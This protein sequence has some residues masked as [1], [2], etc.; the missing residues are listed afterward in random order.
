MNHVDFLKH[1][2]RREPTTIDFLYAA[3][4]ERDFNN[5]SWEE[6]TTRFLI[7][8][9][10]PFRD[11][12]RSTPHEFLY[13]EVRQALPGAYIDF[14]FFPTTRDRAVLEAGGVPLM[15]GIASAK[16]AADFDVLLVSNAYTLEM[17]NLAPYLAGSGLPVTRTGRDSALPGSSYP[18]VAL[19]GSNAMASAALYDEAT[20]DSLVDALFFGEGEGSVGPLAVHLAEASRLQGAE[21]LATLAAAAREVPGFWPTA[22]RMPVTQTKASPEAYPSGNPPVLAGE[23]SGTSRLEITRGC[24]SFCTFCFEG[25]ERKPFRERPF[26]SSI[27]EARRLKAGAGVDSIEL[28]SYNFNAHSRVVDIIKTLHEAFWSVSFQSQRVDMLARSPGLVTFEVAAGKR[29]FTIGVEGISARVRAYYTKE[30]CEADLRA[31]LERIVGEGAREIKLFYILSG[32][33]TDTDLAEF[34]GFISWMRNLVRER[35]SVPRIMFSAGELIRMPFTPL[36]YERLILDEAPYLAIRAR[37]EAVIA[38]AGFEYR[39]PERFDEYCL[40]QVLAL[41]PAGSLALLLALSARGHVYDRNLSRGAWDFTRAWLQE[42]GILAKDS[43][44]TQAPVH[45]NPY[46]DEKPRGYPFPY[47]F[48]TPIATRDIVYNR[49]LDA[50][51]A[52]ERVSCLGATCVGCGACNDDNEGRAERAFLAAHELDAASGHDLRDIES[53]VTAKRKPYETFV[54]ANLP[55]EAAAAPPAYPAVLF[56]RAL[57]AAVPDFVDTVWTASDSFLKSKD[58]LERL[59]GAWGDTQYRLLSSRPLDPDQLTSAGYVVSDTALAPGRLSVD[60]SFPTA[61]YAETVRLVSDFMT[62]AAM[63][64]TLRKTE[65]AATFLIAEKG[66]RKRNVLEATAAIGPEGGMTIKLVCGSKYDLGAFAALAEK[67]KIPYETRVSL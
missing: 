57:F 7:V 39:S 17:V 22:I 19:G 54:R 50:K 63:P 60:L 33:E 16:G 35:S 38:G 8:R 11:V 9:L 28:A 4:S 27:A 34:S 26:E 65:A 37:F 66:R 6:A 25:W 41:P 61:R 1:P 36:A 42:R 12:E 10:S 51:Q 21:R 2:F 29:T 62:A 46:L 23:E 15:H 67:R 31:V 24:P 56:R 18:I 44:G 49:F 48:V 14:G 53:I 47:A 59:P 30:L 20:G 13:R 3:H 40:S 58:G 32:F 52:R 43:A 5:P 45:V 55:R 64:Y